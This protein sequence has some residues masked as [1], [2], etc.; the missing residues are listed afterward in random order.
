MPDARLARTRNPQPTVPPCLRLGHLYR[1]LDWSHQ[2][3]VC[4]R[5]HHTLTRRDLRDRPTVAD[6]T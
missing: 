6:L 5:C 4:L 2:R 1:L 3:V